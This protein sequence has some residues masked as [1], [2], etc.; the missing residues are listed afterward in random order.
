VAV[1]QLE[2]EDGHHGRRCRFAGGSTFA[3]LAPAIATPGGDTCA[4]ARHMT[5]SRDFLAV[6]HPLDVRSQHEELLVD[7]FVATVDVIK[8]ADFRAALSI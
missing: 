4:I 2:R 6:L 1:E 5:N 8:A 3:R 7:V